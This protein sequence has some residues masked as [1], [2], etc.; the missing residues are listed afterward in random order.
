MD[1]GLMSPMPGYA[2]E[3]CGVTVTDYTHLSQAEDMEYAVWDDTVIDAPIFND[4]LEAALTAEVL[5]RFKGSY[6]D[7][8]PAL[9]CNHV[10]NGLAYYY[11]AGFSIETAKIFLE[12][13]GFAHPYENLVELPE[14]TELAVR[15]KDGIDYMFIL[16][17]L[18]QEVKINVKVP[19]EDMLSERKLFGE[20]VLKGYEVAILKF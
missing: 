5:A 20:N 14:E 13:L 19:A 11:G 15:S 2:S 9:V 6:Y 1:L 7:G 8:A 12:K 3:I 10:G 16:N 18:P 17:Y 4:I